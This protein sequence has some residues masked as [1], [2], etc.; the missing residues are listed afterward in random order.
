MTDEPP[1]PS[2]STPPSPTPGAAPETPQPRDP[3]GRLFAPGKTNVQFIYVLYLIGI[4]IFAATIVGLV[5]AYV[6]RGRSAPWLETHYR[7]QIR[8]FWIGVLYA[9]IALLTVFIGIGF[10][11]AIAVIVWAII[12]V[13]RG[14]QRASAGQPILNPDSWL[15]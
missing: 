1:S 5:T 8:T 6:N 2:H 4:V 12:R 9:L 13:V 11:L 3:F 14:L 7:Y 15:L 10:L